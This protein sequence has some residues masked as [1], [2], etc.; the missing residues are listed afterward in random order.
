M[1]PTG[2][3]RFLDMQCVMMGSALWD[4]AYCL[5]SALSIADRRAHELELLDHYLESLADA[6]GPRLSRDDVILE[7]RRGFLFGWGWLLTPYPWQSEARVRAMVARHV[8]AMEDHGSM[9]LVE[10]MELY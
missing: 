4:V 6:G 3:P 5:S 10:S 9:E 8:A 7:F 1:L 2:Q